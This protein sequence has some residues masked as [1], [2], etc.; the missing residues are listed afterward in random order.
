MN[1][2]NI[3][4]NDI[5]LSKV[6][7]SDYSKLKNLAKAEIERVRDGITIVQESI[8]YGL[9]LDH[10]PISMDDLHFMYCFDGDGGLDLDIHQF[11]DL[12][13][14]PLIKNKTLKVC[15]LHECNKDKPLPMTEF[16]IAYNGD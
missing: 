2:S 14:S 11:Y 15:N 12:Y 16:V 9:K 4:K 5:N 6:F 3:E 13:V 1:N 7:T 10:N 8:I